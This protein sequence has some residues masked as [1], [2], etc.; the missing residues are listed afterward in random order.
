MAL[1]EVKSREVLKEIFDAK[2]D[3]QNT[4]GLAIAKLRYFS[5]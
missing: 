4:G 5:L 2:E 3:V 1:E